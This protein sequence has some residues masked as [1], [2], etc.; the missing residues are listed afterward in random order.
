MQEEKIDIFG[1][2]RPEAPL[3]ALP[4]GCRVVTVGGVKQCPRR[5]GP[6]PGCLLLCLVL[7][8]WQGLQDAPRGSLSASKAA[9]QSRWAD[10]ELGGNGD[11]VATAAGEAADFA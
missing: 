1:A 6:G 4:R 9:G 3:Q 11:G 8:S 5:A 10:A 2:E 7:E